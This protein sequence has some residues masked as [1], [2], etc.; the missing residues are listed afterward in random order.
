MLTSPGPD[1]AGNSR[2][3]SQNE[4]SSAPV[5]N[6]NLVQGTRVYDPPN[7]PALTTRSDI[8]ISQLG[9]HAFD[10][11]SFTTNCQSRKRP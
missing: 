2:N 6:Q 10:E 4:S 3:R 11:C 8:P 7:V 5:I 9:P 1:P